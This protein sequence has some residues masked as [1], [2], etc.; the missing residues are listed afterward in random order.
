[1]STKIH[2]LVDALGN[3]VG[4]Y[5]TGGE[6]HDLAG[7][8]HLLPGMQA[9]TLIA[10]KAFDATAPRQPDGRPQLRSSP[11]QR[12]PPDRELLRQAQAVPR[13]RHT[14]RQDQA[15]LSRRYTTR[16]SG[17]LAQLRTRPS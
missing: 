13:H 1:L 12:P 6:V 5:L 3:P 9:D 15:Q 14:L 4:F 11:I 2:A 10:D 16:L 7:A 8:D 17:H